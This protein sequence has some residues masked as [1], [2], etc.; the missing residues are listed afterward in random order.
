VRHGAI[1]D[2][3]QHVAQSPIIRVQGID[4]NVQP[5]MGMRGVLASSFR[6]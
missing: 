3:A 5:A 1:H 6:V 4:E 2:A